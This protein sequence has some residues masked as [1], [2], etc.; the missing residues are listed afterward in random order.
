MKRMYEEP[1]LEMVKFNA[2]ADIMTNS[3]DTVDFDDVQNVG[4]N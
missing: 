2:D 3:V 4:T 1:Q